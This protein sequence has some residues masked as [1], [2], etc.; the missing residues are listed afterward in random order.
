MVFLKPSSNSQI[1]DLAISDGQTE[2]TTL[3]GP[4]ISELKPLDLRPFYIW[5]GDMPQKQIDRLDGFKY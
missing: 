4:K 5:L 1:R 2:G 3:L